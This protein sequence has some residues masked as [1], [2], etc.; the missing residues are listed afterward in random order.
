MLRCVMLPANPRLLARLVTAVILSMVAVVSTTGVAAPLVLVVANAP[1]RAGEMRLSEAM[2][3]V[4]SLS[5]A[6]WPSG[7]VVVLLRPGVY[8]LDAPLR[9]GSRHSGRVDAPL[10]LKSSSEGGAVLSGARVIRWHAFATPDPSESRL[11][12]AARPHVRIVNLIDQGITD[13]GEIKRQGQAR[14]IEPL[15]LEV[16]FQGKPMALAQ[17]PNADYARIQIAGVGGDPRI[18]T[19]SGGRAAQWSREADLWMTGYWGQDWA[20][21]WI[22]VESVDVKQG[23]LRMRDGPPLYAAKPGQRVKVVNALTELDAPGEWYLDRQTGQLYFW[24]PM[25]LRD[26]DVEV[27][28]LT[29]VVI[30]DG[31][32]HVRFEGI[33]F[34]G[35]RGDG[36]V[37]Q[38][39]RDVR[40]VRARIRNVGNRAVRMQGRSHAVIDSDIHDTGQGGISMWGGDR[41]T[42]TAAELLA[43]G[44]RIRRFNRWVK[45]YRPAITLGGVGNS[46]RGNLVADGTHAGLIFYGNDHLIEFNEF[47]SLAQETGDVGAIYTG[48]DWTARGTVI[49]Y[50]FLRDIR[51]PGRWGSQGIY[52]DDQAS[53]IVVRSNLFARVDRAVFI[54]G[55]RDNVVENNLFVDSSPAIHVDARGRTWQRAATQDPNGVLRERLR[56]VPYDRSPYSDRYPGLVRLLEED[57][58]SPRG[59]VLR[60]NAVVGGVALRLRDGTEAEVKVDQLFGDADVTFSTGRP[61]DSRQDP[62]AFAIDRAARAVQDGFTAL[63]LTA[64]GC[65]AR[66][67][68]AADAEQP[69]AR[70]ALIDCFPAQAR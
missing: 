19:L 2:A 58:G 1:T 40:I 22:G 32:S 34:E 8:R 3:Q 15:P 51:G 67:W 17:W 49:R 24:P 25:P 39:G 12:D 20:D 11:T 10:V 62:E 27:S 48:R 45:T 50:N 68:A 53:G 41:K 4:E 43:Q 28:M 60:R 23:A 44:N 9:F 21:E 42:L 55:G 38:G 30:M 35:A 65:A 64:M 61:Q 7:G 57:P 54:G 6:S 59:N 16:Y 69:R 29:S 33:D 36:V 66:R 5:A 31:A 26:D 63:P 18:V 37:I 14:D 70:T 47:H 46:V 56:A 52:L 13:F